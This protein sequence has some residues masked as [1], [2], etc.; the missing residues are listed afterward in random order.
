M[1][2]AILDGSGDGPRA[3]HEKNEPEVREVPEA[4]SDSAT[5]FFPT[6]SALAPAPP[7]EPP[8]EDFFKGAD[9]FASLSLDYAASPPAELPPPG[10]EVPGEPSLSS[11]S[12]LAPPA[13]PEVEMPL[14]EATVIE[15]T[16]VEEVEPV[17]PSLVTTQPSIAA[18]PAGA[19][20][21]EF[22]A[23]NDP[24]RSADAVAPPAA[25]FTT[26]DPLQYAETSVA[27]S[28][29]SRPRTEELDLDIGHFFRGD[30][31]E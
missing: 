15:A 21:L 19:S 18:D 12:E 17:P 6:A 27:A 26:D 14:I 16:V 2:E 9:G 31:P 24:F 8:E 25:S 23:M 5:Q 11:F 10:R 4:R 22:F 29:P 28:L 13:A 7:P 3:A 20:G 30:D 1:M